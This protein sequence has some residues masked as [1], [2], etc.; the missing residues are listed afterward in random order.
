MI[1]ILCGTSNGVVRNQGCNHACCHA[2]RLDSP[3]C[4]AGNCSERRHEASA[5][6]NSL[7][8][9]ACGTA[10]CT[11]CG[12]HVA[13][14]NTIFTM[15]PHTVFGQVTTEPASINIDA[16]AVSAIQLPPPING[17][18]TYSTIADGATC[19]RDKALSV[20]LTKTRNGSICVASCTRNM[21]MQIRSPAGNS[22]IHLLRGMSMHE[23]STPWPA[24]VSVFPPMQ[25]MNNKP[26]PCQLLQ[27]LSQMTCPQLHVASKWSPITQLIFS[28]DFQYITH[29]RYNAHV[30]AEPIV[31]SSALTPTK[32]AV[33]NG[34]FCSCCRRVWGARSTDDIARCIESCGEPGMVDAHLQP[35][36]G[37]AHR[38]ENPKTR[39]AREPVASVIETRTRDAIKSLSSHVVLKDLASRFRQVTAPLLQTP[40]ADSYCPTGGSA[41]RALT[42]LFQPG[43][44]Q[45]WLERRP[46]SLVDAWQCF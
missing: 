2:C 41:R 36:I 29:P 7:P 14:T 28:A 6:A 23:T 35:V 46:D 5:P 43:A 42:L 9:L 15:C 17:R 11:L 19:I 44:S 18:A 1:C 3:V 32:H 37:N 24:T 12:V 21:V 34:I 25:I 8:D 16:N 4:L 30:N 20:V 27:F 39:I 10:A 26:W 33:L 13:I 22:T 31:G 45:S 40:H 38:I